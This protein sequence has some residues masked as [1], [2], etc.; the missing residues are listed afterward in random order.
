[1]DDVR[2]L[3][4]R[5]RSMPRP[6]IPDFLVQSLRQNVAEE[7]SRTRPSAGLFLPACGRHRTEVWVVSYAVAILSSVVLGFSL[8]SADPL[9]RTTGRHSSIYLGKQHEPSL[10]RHSRRHGAERGQS[11]ASEFLK[12]RADVAA[13]SPSVNPKGTLIELTQA[14]GERRA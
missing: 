10:A 9:G 4:Q 14:P 6:A 5:L 7:L 1:M 3:R 12:T 2:E 11:C 8:L 13:E